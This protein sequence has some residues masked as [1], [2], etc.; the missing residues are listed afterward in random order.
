MCIRD[1]GV[2][3]YFEPK[4]LGVGYSNI[5]DILS[6]NMAFNFVVSLCI[7]KFISW[8]I[9][10]GSGTSGGTLAPLLTIGAVSYTHLDVYKRQM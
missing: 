2:I 6:G 10:L 4:T 9:A 5:T 7:L 8:A 1:R 3:G